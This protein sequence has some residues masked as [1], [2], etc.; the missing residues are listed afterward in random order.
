MMFNM[1]NFQKKYSAGDVVFREG[2]H[3][4]ETYLLLQGETEVLKGDDVVATISE[5]G[6]F[7]G[8]MGTLRQEPRTATIRAKTDCVFV[9][10]SPIDFEKIIAAQ[11]NIA[12]K[13]CKLL[14]LRLQSTTNELMKLKKA[15]VC[16]TDGVDIPVHAEAGSSVKDVK[17]IAKEANAE[18]KNGNIDQA[19]ELM[20]EC[21][22]EMP[23]NPK[24]HN[25]L[26]IFYFKSGDKENAIS[27]WEKVVE[28]DPGNEKAKKNLDKLK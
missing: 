4:V 21:V 16:N 15:G 18:Y 1:S 11:P 12:F 10:I 26:A 24:F 3:S 7:I 14:A 22:A 19:I 13:L 8:E 17:A 2:D 20:K 25:N 6:T 28:L 27:E 23:D 9:V 5:T